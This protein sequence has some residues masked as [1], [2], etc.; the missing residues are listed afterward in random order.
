MGAVNTAPINPMT[1]EESAWHQ[2]GT[3][4]GILA[5]RIDENIRCWDSYLQVHMTS[6]PDKRYS[7][8]PRDPK[9]SRD[10]QG[11]RNVLAGWM[12]TRATPP[13]QCLQQGFRDGQTTIK[14]PRQRPRKQKDP[15]SM[16]W[17]IMAWCGIVWYSVV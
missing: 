1:K 14:G 9:A 12:A 3:L 13:L 2:E 5:R 6:A 11:F 10:P 8:T 16:V 7:Y 17:Y 15:K 4:L